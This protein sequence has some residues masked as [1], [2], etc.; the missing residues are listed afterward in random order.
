MQYELI[1]SDRKTIAIQ[2]REGRVIVRAPRRAALRDIEAFV[3]KNAAWI[4]EHMARSQRRAEA[5]P[6]PTTAE[7]AEL[8]AR[9][10]AVLPGRVAHYGAIMGL[11]PSRI[12]ITDARTR[13]G[14]CSVKGSICFSWRLM[15]Y[16]PEAIDYVVVHELAHLRH[17]NHSAEFHAEVARVLPD[18]LWRRAM[19]RG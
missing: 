7:R 5:H 6:E 1:R 10:K 17:M 16:P 18:H 4:A 2:I 13:F 11:H 14:S 12:T 15:M 9:A 3:R 8:I 19:L